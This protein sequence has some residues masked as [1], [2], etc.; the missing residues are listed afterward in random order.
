MSLNDIRFFYFVILL[1]F[2]YFL[3]NFLFFFLSLYIMESYRI[4]RESDSERIWE[5]M[6]G[7][8]MKKLK[9]PNNA[10]I[11]NISVDNE[12]N[13]YQEQDVDPYLEDD[14]ANSEDYLWYGCNF[15]F[16]QYYGYTITCGDDHMILKER[17]TGIYKYLKK[18]RKY[19]NDFLEYHASEFIK[20]KYH[21]KKFYEEITVKKLDMANDVSN[22]KFF[23]KYKFLE[24]NKNF[25]YKKR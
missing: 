14:A 1:I 21:R 4:D 15:R 22:I 5:T 7:G 19:E 2:F 25:N 9:T 18:R 24:Y 6:D 8:I 12:E 16:E 20:K 17:L 3:D 23:N 13:D 10:T 11:N